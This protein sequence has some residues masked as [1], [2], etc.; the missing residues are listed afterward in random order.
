MRNLIT[1]LILWL[2]ARFDVWPIDEARVHMGADKKARSQRWEAFA[3]EEGGLF[4]LTAKIKAQYLASMGKVA[5]GDADALEALA[6]GARVCDQLD[7]QVRT[8]IAAGE[9]EEKQED[10]AAR[11]A[12]VPI[13]KSV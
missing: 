12:A 9:V 5:P 3:K 7:A 10:R 4:D 8:V 13:R 11:F 1:R 2:C 6:I